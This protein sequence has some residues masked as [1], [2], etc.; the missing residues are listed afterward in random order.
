MKNAKNQMLSKPSPET[1]AQMLQINLFLVI[2]CQNLFV[3]FSLINTP[4]SNE[5]SNK[6]VRNYLEF[7]DN[8]PT[9]KKCR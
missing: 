1:S 5:S 7:S 3:V 6:G 8:P 2:E 9:P 4:I